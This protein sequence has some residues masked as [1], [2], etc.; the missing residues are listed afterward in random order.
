MQT[1]IKKKAGVSI[2]ISDKMDFR[3]RKPLET[4]RDITNDKRINLPGRHKNLYM[5]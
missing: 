3:A 5:Y 2:L 4:K 1:L